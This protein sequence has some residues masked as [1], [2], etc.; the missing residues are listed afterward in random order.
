MSQ[1]PRRDEPTLNLEAASSDE[2]DRVLISVNTRDYRPVEEEV[3]PPPA[4]RRCDSAHRE[5][6][7]QPF[8]TD[9]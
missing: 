8:L 3:T 5:I 9:W 6:L 2:L 1:S 7:R 4:K